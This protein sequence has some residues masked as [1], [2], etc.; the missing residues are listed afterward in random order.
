MRQVKHTD[1]PN[2]IVLK[3]TE[4]QGEIDRCIIVAEDFDNPP[5]KL[6]Y[7]GLNYHILSLLHLIQDWLEED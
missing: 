1:A 3:Y 2:Y 6:I 4:L 7:Q 5:Q